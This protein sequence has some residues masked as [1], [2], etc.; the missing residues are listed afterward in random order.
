MDFF[1]SSALAQSGGEAGGGLVSLIPLV[2]IFVLFYFLLIRPQQKKTKQHKA[3]VESLQVGD[4]VVTNGGLL[5]RI[6]KVDTYAVDM[7][8]AKDVTVQIQRNS[9]AQIV[10][11]GTVTASASAT[12]PR[13]KKKSSSAETTE[14]EE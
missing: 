9:I 14:N 12:K 8:I 10:P 1:I 13:K 5:G 7:T 6:S 4:E 2:L 3:M 11:E